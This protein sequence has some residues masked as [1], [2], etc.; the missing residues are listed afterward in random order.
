MPYEIRK[1]DGGY[2]VFNKET[3]ERKNE[4][5]YPSK[6]AALPY[7]KKLYSVEGQDSATQS[8]AKRR[9]K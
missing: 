9:K 7:M 2:A 3:G 1:V 4:K 6:D 8:R 5:P